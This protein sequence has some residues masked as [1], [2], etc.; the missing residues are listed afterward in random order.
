MIGGFIGH[1]IYSNGVAEQAQDP[2]VMNIQL[3]KMQEEGQGVPT[4][5][6]FA[7]LA[8]NLSGKQGKVVGKL[9]KKYTGT[10]LFSEAL[11]D[12]KNIPKLQAMLHNP[13]V[14]DAIRAQTGMPRDAND[15]NK[16][17]AEQYAELINGGHM[18][19]KN[20]LNTGEGLYVLSALQQGVA[21]NVDV[22]VTPDSRN[23]SRSRNS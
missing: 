7:T 8:A 15:P 19:V 11:A 20:M 3:M 13:V 21:Y 16:T 5:A 18:Q 6:V 23:H 9:L 1:K 17:V 10:E 4:E 2:V 14:D 12:P 22:P